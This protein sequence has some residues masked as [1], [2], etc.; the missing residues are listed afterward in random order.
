[1]RE[2]EFIVCII[3]VREEQKFLSIQTCLLENSIR[4]DFQNTLVLPRIVTIL[5]IIKAPIEMTQT[6]RSVVSSK[7]NTFITF[8]V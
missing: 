5:F 8:Q 7:R 6:L 2:L 4:R 1:M 3:V